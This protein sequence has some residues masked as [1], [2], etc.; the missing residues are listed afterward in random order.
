MIKIKYFDGAYK[1][2]M[3]SLDCEHNIRRDV[4][5][6]YDFEDGALSRPRL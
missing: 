5:D 6:R 4:N 2:L 3:E 1:R